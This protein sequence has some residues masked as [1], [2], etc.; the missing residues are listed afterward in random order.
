MKKQSSRPKEEEPPLKDIHELYGIFTNAY[1]EPAGR[2]GLVVDSVTGDPTIVRSSSPFTK[3]VLSIIAADSVGNLRALSVHP[4]EASALEAQTKYCRHRMS[5]D[6]SALGHAFGSAEKGTHLLMLTSDEK[7]SQIRIGLVRHGKYFIWTAEDTMAF[8]WAMKRWKSVHGIELDTGIALMTPAMFATQPDEFMY[9]E[10]IHPQWDLSKPVDVAA[11]AEFDKVSGLVRMV[12]HLRLAGRPVMASD[13]EG[14]ELAVDSRLD[15]P[16]HKRSISSA[17]DTAKTG[18]RK[19][20]AR[21]AI[22]LGDPPNT[23]SSSSSSV[24]AIVTAIR[25]AKS[26]KPLIF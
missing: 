15:T 3:A 11:A 22:L 1:G 17:A 9:Q 8:L 13:Y 26:N 24:S 19:R 18:D 4:D 2:F 23:G 14:D 12:H 6:T 10:S 5:V 20:T 21:I 16:A 7:R 25:S